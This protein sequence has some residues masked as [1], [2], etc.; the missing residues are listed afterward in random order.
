MIPLVTGNMGNQPNIQPMPW[1]YHPLINTFGKHPIVK[2]MGAIHLKFVSTIDTVRAVGIQKTPL[3]FTSPYT[4]TLGT[5]YLVTFNEARKD[6]QNP[7]LKEYN[8]GSLP[9]AYLL[10]GAF[11]S[12]F[13]IH[14][15]SQRKDFVGQSKP[16]KILVCADGDILRNDINPKTRQATSLDRDAFFG[17]PYSNKDFI[18]NALDYMIDDKGTILAKQKQITLRPLDK[19]KLQNDRLFW[20]VFNMLVPVLIVLL[21]GILFSFLRKRAY[22]SKA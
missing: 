8:K 2:N 22:T 10:E 21:F 5:P 11:S 19:I 3:L 20:Q 14:S 17:T 9:V 4:K 18:M 1:K 12:W 16:T 15:F 6:V 13:K 7:N